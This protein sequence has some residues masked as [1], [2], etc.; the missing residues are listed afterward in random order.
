MLYNWYQA[1]AH[2]RSYLIRLSLISSLGMGQSLIQLTPHTTSVQPA[3]GAERS[4]RNDTRRLLSFANL[5]HLILILP[6]LP[7]GHHC[8]SRR[9]LT[10]SMATLNKGAESGDLV[11]QVL[12]SAGMTGQGGFGAKA[13]NETTIH[14]Q[15]EQKTI[16]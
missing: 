14:G 8:T 10:Q 13:M 6:N 12:D 11:A 3:L 9:M 16:D 15:Q 2:G 4:P 1:K 5:H 7:P